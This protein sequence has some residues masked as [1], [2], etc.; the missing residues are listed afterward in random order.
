LLPHIDAQ[1][2]PLP[3]LLIAAAVCLVLFL[4]VQRVKHGEAGRVA[5]RSRGDDRRPR[6]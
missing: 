3:V 4:L 5:R 6:R 2:N 1:A